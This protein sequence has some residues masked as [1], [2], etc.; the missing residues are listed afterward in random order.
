MC[1]G[2]QVNPSGRK[3]TQADAR[4]RKGAQVDASRVRA[5]EH[6]RG[7]KGTQSNPISILDSLGDPRDF[8][9]KNKKTF[10]WY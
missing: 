3:G 4:T 10:G 8:L 1:A 2:A 7:R 6:S 5:Q 9:H